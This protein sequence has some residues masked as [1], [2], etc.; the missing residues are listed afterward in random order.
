M[1]KFLTF[2]AIVSLLAGCDRGNH[3]KYRRIKLENSLL[4]EISG[5]GLTSPSY[6]FGTDHLIG[7]N[8]LDTLPWVIKRF[9]ECRAVAGERDI[10]SGMRERREHIFLGYD[11]L[12]HVLSA[13]EF[14]EIDKT[15]LH[16]VPYPLKQF[17]HF[18]PI[19]VYDYLYTII[20]AKTESRTNRYLDGFF[21]DTA[22]KLG[23][24][25]IGL[26]STRF[27]DSLL[28][29]EPLDIQKAKLL[30]LVRHIDLYKKT[31][32]RFFK[33]YHEQDLTG[34]E[35]QDNAKEVFTA[36]NLD[37]VVRYRDQMWLRELPAIMKQQPTFIAVG[38]GH[39]LWDCGLINQLRLKGYTV[40]PVTK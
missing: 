13:D 23:Y 27:H 28:Y 20:S 38:A 29:D 16:Y 12:T 24:K 19:Y 33:L 17:D 26:E 9:K 40:T 2:L 34:M 6:L 37:F 39:L 8:F 25:I 7:R 30:R 22:R 21:Q 15:L 31:S 3:P 11:S 36:G 4:W 14:A 10:D 1:K 32:I 18:K 5:N 35:K